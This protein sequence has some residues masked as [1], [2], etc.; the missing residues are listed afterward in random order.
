[1][2]LDPLHTVASA[3]LV[4]HFRATGN[5]G[6]LDSSS[7]VLQAYGNIEKGEYKQLYYE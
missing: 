4:N 7:N 2:F 6:R 3:G 5:D 1:V